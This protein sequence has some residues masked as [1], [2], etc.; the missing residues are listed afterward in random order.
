MDREAGFRRD[1]EV[2]QAIRKRVGRDVKLMVDANNG[3]DLTS[4]KR[5]LDAVGDELFF[6][7]EMFPE[8]V[9]E[10][11]ELKAYLKK[12]GWKTLVADGES[13][14]EVSHFDA[15]I[16]KQAL[17]VLQPDMRRFGFSLQWQL[18]QKAAAVPAIKLAPH[19]WGSFLG[20][21]MQVVL[22]RGIGNMLMA[23]QD[24]SASDLFD[25]SAFAFK[26]GLMTVPDEPGCGLR[27]RE[28]V[29]KKKYAAQAWVVK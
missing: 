15:F 8:T 16:A 13:A 2:V 7:E 10:D 18:S 9:A 1:V 26:D 23:E 11:L 20:L 28:E 22:G 6:V 4:T 12:K 14:N 5:W 27:L 24:T 3:Y 21:Y 25:T 17:D 19:N 29:F